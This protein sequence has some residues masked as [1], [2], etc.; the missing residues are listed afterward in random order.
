MVKVPKL[1][2]RVI[3]VAEHHPFVT[4]ALR[5]RKHYEQC[6]CG[7]GRKYKKCHKSRAQEEPVSLASGP[8][9]KGVFSG[10]SAG[11]KRIRDAS[12]ST[13]QGAVIDAAHDPEE[14]STGADC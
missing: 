7:S 3:D 14:G 11:V 13:C 6:W 4:E 5:P 10:E 2:F 1:P 8:L 12:D 9:S